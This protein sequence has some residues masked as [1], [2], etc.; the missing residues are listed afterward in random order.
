M[1]PPTIA[2]RMRATS[3]TIGAMNAPARWRTNVPGYARVRLRDVYPGVDL[4]YMGFILMIIG[5]YVT[6]FTSHQ[7][8]GIEATRRGAVTRV[9]VCGTANKNKAALER[10]IQRLAQRLKELT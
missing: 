5:C 10:R 8:L 6:F 3:F 7:Q 4:V 1:G 2:V 9:T